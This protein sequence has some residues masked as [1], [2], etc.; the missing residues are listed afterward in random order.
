MRKRK[1]G[2]KLSKKRDQRKALLKSLAISL[3]LKEKIKTTEAKAKETQ[4]FIEKFITKAKKGDLASRRFLARFFSKDIVK[5]LI[6]EIAPRYKE[7]KGGYTRII[8]LGPR[9]TDGAK[10][11]IIELIK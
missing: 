8:K 6:N 2:R 9:K 3:L 10:M 7:R 11:A 1:K 4:S 5:K